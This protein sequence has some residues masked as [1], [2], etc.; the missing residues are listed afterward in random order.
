[1]YVYFPRHSRTWGSRVSLSKL[2]DHTETH[3]SR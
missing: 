3:H 1:M 2:H